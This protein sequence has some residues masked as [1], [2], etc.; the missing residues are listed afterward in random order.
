MSY[1]IRYVTTDNH[2]PTLE[3]LEKGLTSV[4]PR[5]E[6]DGDVIVFDD[7]DYGLVEINKLGD[8]TF[9]SDIDLL[10]SFAAEKKNKRSLLAVLQNAKSMLTVQPIWEN[11]DEDAT[12]GVLKPLWN[13]LYANHPGLLIGEGGD[14][15]TENDELIE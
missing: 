14:F 3:E 6:I 8:G 15:I 13:L 11:R 5:Y 1:Y 4:D 7:E 10:Q 12:L 2:T 9:E